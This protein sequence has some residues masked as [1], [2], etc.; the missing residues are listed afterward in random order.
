MVLVMSN[1]NT[2]RNYI[3]NCYTE[4]EKAEYWCV[5]VCVYVRECSDEKFMSNDDTCTNNTYIDNTTRK[6]NAGNCIYV[7]V[8]G[9]VTEGM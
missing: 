8:C 5:C 4:R 2:C 7:C 9:W 1:D 3:Y 6:G